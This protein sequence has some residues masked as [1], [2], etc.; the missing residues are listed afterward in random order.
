[1]MYV[2]HQLCSSMPRLCRKLPSTRRAL[3][4]A[5]TPSLQDDDDDD[6]DDDEDGVEVFDDLNDYDAKEIIPRATRRAA[7]AS[8]LARAPA[9]GSSSSS[10][11]SSAAAR[12]RVPDEE[13]EADF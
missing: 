5:R 1:M 13:E 10:S 6:D 2:L 12:P 7:A 4:P 9:G 11:S 8:G 3:H